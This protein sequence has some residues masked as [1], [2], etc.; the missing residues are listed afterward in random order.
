MYEFI[1]LLYFSEILI[2][3]MVLSVQVDECRK[4][5]F[6]K[7]GHTYHSIPTTQSA[8]MQH[9]RRA[10]Y[11]GGFVWGQSLNLKP[12]L[13]SPVEW[14]WLYNIQYKPNWTLLP[15]LSQTCT[16][17]IRCGC[18]VTSR[19][20]CRCKRSNLQCTALCECDG[21]CYQ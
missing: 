15:H 19:G 4:Y 9:I 11:Q 10:T 5:L 8:P 14:G 21:K 13:P 18:E 7:K 2:D 6:T 17:L 12:I 16:E 3:V 1:R 20:L